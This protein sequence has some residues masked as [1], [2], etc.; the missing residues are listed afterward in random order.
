M[1]RKSTKSA[2]E[3]AKKLR[4][5]RF[6][7]TVSD[8]WLTDVEVRAEDKNEAVEK[9]MRGEGSFGEPYSPAGDLR[10]EDIEKR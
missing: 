6:I 2:E 8:C 9:A 7:V 1:P 4:E 5:K 3:V 10:F